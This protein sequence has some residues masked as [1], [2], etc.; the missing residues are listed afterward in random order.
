[1]KRRKL[2]TH[3]VHI[4]LHI[5]T[6][7]SSLYSTY[8]C[9]PAHTHSRTEQS[10]ERQCSHKHMVNHQKIELRFSSCKG[11]RKW[12]ALFI[13]GSILLFPLRFIFLARLITKTFHLQQQQRRRRRKPQ[14]R[15]LFF[16]I[17]LSLSPFGLCLRNFLLHENVVYSQQQPKQKL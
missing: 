1:M 4:L 8:K 6:E 7:D 10:V 15:I 9:T 17:S 16:C 2:S 3:F 13:F 5:H 11:V 12:S 14:R